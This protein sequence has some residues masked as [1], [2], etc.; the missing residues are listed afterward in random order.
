MSQN[1]ELLQLVMDAIKCLGEKNGTIISEYEIAKQALIS[2]NQLD[3][4]ISG[5]E[6]VPDYIIR[7]L[8]D[9]HGLEIEYLTD[10]IQLDIEIP[11]DDDIEPECDA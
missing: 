7:S 4:F 8:Q 5:Q 10:T 3:A 1:K 6:E 11:D 9:F 2:K